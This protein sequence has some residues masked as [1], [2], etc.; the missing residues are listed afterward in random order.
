MLTT[1]LQVAPAR[2]QLCL[3]LVNHARQGLRCSFEGS[4]AWLPSGQGSL[5]SP[6]LEQVRQLVHAME[7]NVAN[8]CR[9]VRHSKGKS[10][11]IAMT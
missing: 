5:P 8:L 7:D 4:A 6:L 2:F 11:H 10:G 3:V 9:L 1:D